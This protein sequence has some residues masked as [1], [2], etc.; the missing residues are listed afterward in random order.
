MNLKGTKRPS[1]NICSGCGAEFHV[2]MSP[3]LCPKCLLK[4]GLPSQ[5]VTLQNAVPA[6]SSRIMPQP[7]EQFGHYRIIRQIGQGGMGAVFEAEDLESGRRVALKIMSHTLDSRETRARF[8]REGRLAASINHPNSVYIFG[9]EEIA[10]MPVI[11]MEFVAGGTL[12]DRVK[13]KGLLPAT[14]AA[15][16]ILQVIDGLEAAQRIGVL[17]RDVKPSNCFIGYDGKVKI[18]D[19]GLSINTAIRLEPTLTA[20]G[21]FMGTPTFASPEQL[22]GDELTVRSDLY[23][24]GI[25]LYYL[26]TGAVPFTAPNLPQLLA[27]ILEHPV[28]SP[29][30]R[31]NNVPEGLSQIVLRCLEKNPDKRFQNYNELRH[32]LLSYTSTAPVPANLVKRFMAYCVDVLLISMV[33]SPFTYLITRHLYNQMLHGGTLANTESMMM[34]SM[35]IVSLTMIISFSAALLYF[36]LLEGFWGATCGKALFGLRVM[37]ADRGRPGIL[38]ALGRFMVVTGPISLGSMA[39]GLVSPALWQIMLLSV[40]KP[41]WCNHLWTLL[42]PVTIRKHNGFAALQ[43]L[44]TGTRVVQR[45]VNPIRSP[46]SDVETVP[47]IGTD[48][49]R[50]GPYQV[51]EKI[52]VGDGREW[53]L[54]YDASL[55]RKV[56]IRKMKPDDPPVSPSLRNLGRQGRLR[57]LNG[58]RSPAESWDAYEAVPGQPL[59]NLV[60]DRQSWE[61]VRFWLLDLTDEMRAAQTDGSLP[62]RLSPD[63]VWITADNHAKL[64]DFSPP[65]VSQQQDLTA[66]TSQD[67]LRQVAA[68]ALEGRP[69]S[70]DESRTSP[71]AVPLALHA[72]AFLDS[73]PKIADLKEALE[74]LK[75]SLSKPAIV[76]RVRRLVLALGY[77][78]WPVSSLL[79][80][81]LATA[82]LTSELISTRISLLIAIGCSLFTLYLVTI[83]ALGS[84]L[85]FRGGLLM[86]LTGVTVVNRDG[87]PASRGRVFWRNLIAV[88]PLIVL[89][90]LG[91]ICYSVI[92]TGTLSGWILSDIRNDEWNVLMFIKSGLIG[93][94]GLQ[95][96]LTI[97]SLLLPNRS[98]QD[99]LAGTWLVPK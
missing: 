21:A 29:T 82:A 37:R 19:F 53:L 83:F 71:I 49:P 47:D 50:I 92:P 22:R 17:H 77:M 24:V 96:V 85:L 52:A 7:E 40:W 69:T 79:T 16:Y 1:T 27:S 95:V 54:G 91:I 20:T 93:L 34:D 81:G 73:L 58:K 98:L 70:L 36:T 64:M 33:Q 56:W 46:L 30:K 41:G 42:L 89:F 99:R 13:D 59:A 78:A 35:I 63:R 80:V 67:F 90:A 2:N 84:A 44:L 39:I 61:Q 18:G 75:S 68:S 57:W 12:Q 65:G 72:R 31:R 5:S 86:Y 97:V 10:G 51:L 9:T 66:S 11:A 15:D 32:A 55:L 48:L 87:T 14:E 25:T 6:Q 3:G 28:E 88:L 94:V 26:L 74:N 4:A 76:T 45:S 43:D 23:A 8:L 60:R 38:R 62:A